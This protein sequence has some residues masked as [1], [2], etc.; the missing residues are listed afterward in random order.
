MVLFRVEIMT[1]NGNGLLLPEEASAP[2]L[3]HCVVA[4]A[5]VVPCVV[6]G[7]GEL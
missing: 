2:C 1:I 3:H 4:V 7:G 5:V 6:V